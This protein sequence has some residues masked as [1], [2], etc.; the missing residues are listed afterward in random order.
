MVLTYLNTYILA[1]LILILSY[2]FA[3]Q[4]CKSI[5]NESL[6]ALPIVAVKW[7]SDEMTI[8]LCIILV[9]SALGLVR[10]WHLKCNTLGL[11][12]ELRRDLNGKRKY[13]DPHNYFYK[14]KFLLKYYKLCYHNIFQKYLFYKNMI[15]F[16]FL[17]VY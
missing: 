8:I 1:V 4:R 15:F 6:Y 10:C 3:M 11:L 9:E 5:H 12:I 13:I 2:F 7:P 17:K 16:M 14:Y